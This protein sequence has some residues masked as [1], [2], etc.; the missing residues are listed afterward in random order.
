MESAEGVVAPDVN[1]VYD[2]SEGDLFELVFG[3]QIHIGGLASSLEL[4]E[5]AGIEA[6]QHGVDLC[7]CNGAGMRCLVRFKQVAS[8][9]GVDASV[10]TVERGRRRCQEEGMSDRIRI[11]HADACKSGLPTGEADFVWSEDA[12]CYVPDKPSLIAE[13][14]RIVKPGGTIAFTDWIEG[15]TPLS[16]AEKQMFLTGMR[17]D[18]VQDLAGYRALLEKNGCEVI[19]ASDTGRFSAHLDLFANMIEKQLTYDALKIMDFDEGSVAVL[20]AGFRLG[21]E[22][23]RQGKLAQGRFVARV[24]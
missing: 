18:N 4:A 21:A 14:V 6:G 20:V 15:P 24:S 2:G 19:E 1:A 22:L 7:C 11:I 23:A 10:R 16:E 13:A 9:V 5:R 8:M 3:E 12:W 17:F